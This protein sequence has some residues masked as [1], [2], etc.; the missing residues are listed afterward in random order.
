MT[1][2]LQQYI[3]R[4]IDFVDLINVGA[5]QI[6]VYTITLNENFESKVTLE[7]VISNIEH[8]LP[9]NS[10]IETHDCAFLIVHE[11]REGVWILINWWTDGEIL[12]TEVYFADYKNPT[13]ITNSIYAPKNLICVWELEVVVHERKVWIEH[14]LKNAKNPDYQHYLNDYLIQ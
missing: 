3:S 13:T 10:V 7:T 8:W 6:K 14:V 5:W 1:F 2:K 4:N 9:K 12:E 11:G